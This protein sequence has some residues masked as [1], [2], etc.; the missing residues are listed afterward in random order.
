MLSKLLNIN[1]KFIVLNDSNFVKDEMIYVIYVMYIIN[2]PLKDQIPELKV[3]ESL[4]RQF[5]GVLWSELFQ[6]K[7]SLADKIKEFQ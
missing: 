4:L 6:N 3:S 5:N 7:K 2:I 1:P